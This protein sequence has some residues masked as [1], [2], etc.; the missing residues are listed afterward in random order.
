MVRDRWGVNPTWSMWGA[1][2]YGGLVGPPLQVVQ[3]ALTDGEPGLAAN[4]EYLLW[5]VIAGSA[6]FMLAAHARN[7]VLLRRSGKSD[8]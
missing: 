3:D 8:H 4:P 1:A 2:I 6:A 5:G 7:R